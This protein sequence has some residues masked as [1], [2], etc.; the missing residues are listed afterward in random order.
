MLNAVKSPVEPHALTFQSCWLCRHWPPRGQHPQPPH[1][2]ATHFGTTHNHIQPATT[3][4]TQPATLIMALKP[5]TFRRHS[6]GRCDVHAHAAGAHQVPDPGPQ[7]L[8]HPTWPLA[9]RP[10]PCSRPS[11]AYMR[12]ACKQHARYMQ[13]TCKPHLAQGHEVCCGRV[14]HEGGGQPVM[15]QLKRGQSRTCV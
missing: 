12:A 13:A 11:S 14:A 6:A 10:S 2:P 8:Q 15:C 1:P 3:S 7:I 4:H 9:M 5:T